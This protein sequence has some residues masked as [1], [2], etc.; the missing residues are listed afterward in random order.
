MK[1]FLRKKS[2][3]WAINIK[4]NTKKFFKEKKTEQQVWSRQKD[5]RG[6]R[7]VESNDSPEIQDWTVTSDLSDLLLGYNL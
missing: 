1:I 6:D 7:K 5:K 2:G 4:K 3:E